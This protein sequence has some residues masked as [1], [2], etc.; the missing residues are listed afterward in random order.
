MG[1]FAILLLVPV[2]WQHV[3]IRRDGIHYEKKNKHAMAFFFFFLTALVALRHETVGADTENYIYYFNKYAAMSWDEV[4]ATPTEIGF[5]CLNKLVSLFTENHQVF[6]GVVAVVTLAMIYPT[7]RRLCVDA[8]LTIALFCFMSTFVVLFSGIR[9]MLAVGI[10]MLAYELTRN[11][12]L[13]FFIL[14]VGVATLFHTSA[15][16]LVFMYP[17]YHAKITKKWMFAVV[18]G[19]FVVLIFNRQI[20]AALGWILRQF[21][22]YEATISSTGAYTTLILMIAFDVLAFLIPDESRMDEETMGLRNLLQF[23]LVLQMFAPLHSWSMRMNYYYLILIPL[24]MPKVIQC[25]GEKWKQLATVSRHVMVIFFLVYFFL[26]NS[27]SR[28]LYVF[29]YH[30]FWEI[31]P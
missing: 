21:T 31:V 26:V 9:Q 6:F 3:V 5:V 11:K 19:L 22:K 28:T 27:G 2:F 23:S 8:S 14:V 16:M 18:P 13:V 1:V 12:K 7:Y 17:L 24:L 20:F 25:K 30:F 29:P 4:L 15:F 10:G